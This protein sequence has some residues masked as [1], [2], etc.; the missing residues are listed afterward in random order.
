LYDIEAEHLGMTARL[1]DAF[2]VKATARGPEL[3]TQIVGERSLRVRRPSRFILK[4]ENAGDVEMPAP[5]FQ[6]QHTSGPGTV[7]FRLEHETAEHEGAIQV[8]GIHP[9]GMAGWFP[10]GAKGE[11][12]GFFV[13]EPES[14][15]ACAT[16]GSPCEVEIEILRF[17]PLSGVG[18][19]WDRVDARPAG[20][21]EEA[22]DAAWPPLSASLGGSWVD[23]V[24][25]LGQIATRLA[26][27]GADASSVKT[28]FRFAVGEAEG[29]ASAAIT[30]VLKAAAGLE[31][32]AGLR[33]AAVGGTGDAGC[34]VTDSE[35]AFAIECLDAGEDYEIVVE[36]YRVVSVSGGG[37]T[38]TVP[39]ESGEDLLALEVLA[40]VQPGEFPADCRVC[41]E[42][43]LPEAPLDL[44]DY[45][46]LAARMPAAFV[47]SWDPNDKTGQA[48][49]DE[50]VDLETGA[51]WISAGAEIH[52]TIYF[53]NL[54]AAAIAAETVTIMDTL[55]PTLDLSTFTPG[56]VHVGSY[57]SP[58]Y[59][60]VSFDRL[61]RDLT[62]G[63]THLLGSE[64]YQPQISYPLDI[65][66]E[67]DTGEG[68]EVVPVGVDV[69]ITGP[70]PETR[71]VKWVLKLRSG[72]TVDGFLLPNDSLGQGEGH[73]SFTV[74][75]ESGLDHGEEIPQEAEIQ[76]DELTP[77]S[78]A[79][80]DPV[81]FQIRLLEKPRFPL[82]ADRAR[83]VEP[84]TALVWEG[85]GASSYRIFLWPEGE[86][87]PPSPLAE[88]VE[89]HCEPDLSP[90]AGVTYQWQ[91]EAVRE[92]ADAVELSPVWTFTTHEV[93][94]APQ[95]PAE[96]DPPEGAVVELEEL[97]FSWEALEGAVSY[98]LFIWPEGGDASTA[99]RILGLSAC[100]FEGQLPL[101]RGT[102][103]NWQVRAWNSGGESLGP[104][105]KF[106]V[107]EVPTFIRGDCNGIGQASLDVSDAIT[108]LLY[109]FAGRA[110]P[111]C[112]AACDA[113]GDG[114]VAGSVTDAV[115]L[116]HF[117]FLG[118]AAPP[119]PYPECGPGNDEDAALGCERPVVC[120]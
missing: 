20:M 115:Y 28:L 46:T 2:E 37:S 7:R 120:E 4:Y 58:Y 101:D 78:T 57:P 17:D 81:L 6:I 110:A 65:L 18:V 16:A 117:C 24:E 51:R 29:R 86:E 40:E 90:A 27:R 97:V 52:Y 42:S 60:T 105:L 62:S 113:N 74:K 9:D 11:I 59:N 63:Y 21:S 1:E 39:E 91:V 79:N 92:S 66:W 107:E 112:L 72:E 116:L 106:T 12:P 22:W 75:P 80:P 93:T 33:I 26:H 119:A 47:S 102:Q 100:H 48:G 5:L 64:R 32:L 85:G 53:E 71:E 56:V 50:E 30:G 111:P 31:P 103:Y 55:D 68:T 83:G 36:G 118:G 15:E 14:E 13:Y 104:V 23:Y 95:E 99:T 38:V 73:V 96:Q 109:T 77:I 44:P 10:P 87:R 54:A 49:E 8:L 70:D 3:R 69:E 108:L 98:D 34:A 82:P 88:V 41:D 61:G 84:E 43:G 76:F 114:M 94:A 19:G 25:S 35:G 89:C 67:V 45:F